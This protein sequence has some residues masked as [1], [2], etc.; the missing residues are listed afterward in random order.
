MKRGTK[1]NMFEKFLNVISALFAIVVLVSV[2]KN[3]YGD[4]V[5]NGHI[6][7]AGSVVTSTDSDVADV[8][9]LMPVANEVFVIDEVPVTPETADINDVCDIVYTFFY[10][11]PAELELM[12]QNKKQ[13]FVGK[14]FAFSGTVSDITTSNCTVAV[15]ADNIGWEDVIRTY[16]DI[17][18]ND[19]Y[20]PQGS[21][22]ARHYAE[23]HFFDIK[24]LVNNFY[25]EMPLE[26]LA[27]LKVGDEVIVCGHI[28]DLYA[29]VRSTIRYGELYY[30]NFSIGSSDACIV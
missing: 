9:G 21:G 12:L 17:I 27:E 10:N 20:G 15:V 29:I 1:L 30:T 4:L 26:D 13:E 19:E 28:S 23:Q 14:S 3:M 2:C 8:S 7:D 18:A 11:N 5:S 24:T 22:D 25:V 6:D 16:V